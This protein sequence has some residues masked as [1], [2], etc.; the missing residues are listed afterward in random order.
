MTKRFENRV[1]VVSGGARGL[2]AAMARRLVA[3]GAKVL[4]GDVLQEQGEALAAELGEAC[5]FRR[6]DVTDEAQWNAAVDAAESMGPVHGLVNNAGVYKPV[7]LVAPDSPA[8]F[9]RH[10]EINQYGTF[11]GLRAIVPALERNGGGSIVNISSTVGLRSAPNSIAYTGTKWAV[12]GMT[13]T[14]A[15]ELVGRNIRVNSVHP[16]PTDTEILRVRTD[17]ENRQRVQQV[18]MKR[19]GTPDEVASAVLF[20][21]SDESSYTTGAE[22]AVDGG[23]VL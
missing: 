13:K 1:Y 14:A 9:R 15:L 11:L 18:P 20:L 17:E 2:G 10:M 4:I 19:L 22:L 12:R 16:G 7:S 6:L 23:T 3:D 8:E 5:R 21:L